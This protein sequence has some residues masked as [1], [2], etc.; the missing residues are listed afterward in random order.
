MTKVMDAMPAKDVAEAIISAAKRSADTQNASITG[1]L[2]LLPGASLERKVTEEQVYYQALVEATSVYVGDMNAKILP[3]T[4]QL[5]GPNLS[6]EERVAKARELIEIA[7]RADLIAEAGWPDEEVIRHYSDDPTPERARVVTGAADAGEPGPTPFTSASAKRVLIAFAEMTRILSNLLNPE[8]TTPA[9]YAAFMNVLL[10]KFLFARVDD[11]NASMQAIHA[12]HDS[13]EC[14]VRVLGSRPVRTVWKRTYSA[15]P[16]LDNAVRGY[17]S[18]AALVTAP[19]IGEIQA[20]TL[21]LHPALLD[22]L[23]RE[24]S[25]VTEE[26]SRTVI[27]TLKQYATENPEYMQTAYL[28]HSPAGP[29]HDSV[30]HI[31]ITAHVLTAPLFQMQEAYDAVFS[32]PDWSADLDNLLATGDNQDQSE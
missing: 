15:E 6:H 13:E 31:A 5:Y 11:V 25:R 1:G 7:D 17:E 10:E 2:G 19:N 26:A 23:D 20:C 30:A 9:D 28:E 27:D 12:E 24:S 16:T 4:Q 21:A 22:E 3:I 29:G 14:M 32:A 18:L 8:L